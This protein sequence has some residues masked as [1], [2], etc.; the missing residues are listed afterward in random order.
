MFKRLPNIDLT[1]NSPRVNIR[2]SCAKPRYTESLYKLRVRN[3]E[4]SIKLKCS[5]PLYLKVLYFTVMQQHRNHTGNTNSVHLPYNMYKLTC[6]QDNTVPC[7]SS[8]CSWNA[9]DPIHLIL[10]YCTA[11]FN[12]LLCTDTFGI[13]V[14]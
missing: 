10:Q 9:V 11:I 14:A 8:Y 6:I 4:V 3:I 2:Y 12:A 13:S 7:P 1:Q 5:I